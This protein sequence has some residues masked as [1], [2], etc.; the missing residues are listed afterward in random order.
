MLQAQCSNKAVCVCLLRLGNILV[1]GIHTAS[2]VC[3]AHFCITLPLL[4]LSP[5][6][7]PLLFPPSRPAPSLLSLPQQRE[8]GGGVGRKGSCWE[9]HLQPKSPL[10]SWTVILELA[11]LFSQRHY[12]DLKGRVIEVYSESHCSFVMNTKRQAPLAVTIA[13]CR[14]TKSQFSVTLYT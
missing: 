8:G 12:V 11:V 5:S 14:S 3:T 6:L 13:V 4:C 9:V 1:I 10:K 2:S 7:S